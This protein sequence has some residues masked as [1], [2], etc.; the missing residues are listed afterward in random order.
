MNLFN[1]VQ[2][3]SAG[4]PIRSTQMSAFNMQSHLKV[5]HASILYLVA[6]TSISQVLNDI[7][8]ICFS[9]CLTFKISICHWDA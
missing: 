5:N 2:T 6:W 4:Y 7:T 8:K 3:V 9:K 1:D